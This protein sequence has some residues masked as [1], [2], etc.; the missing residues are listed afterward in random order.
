MTKN[1]SRSGLDDVSGSGS[2]SSSDSA[3]AGRLELA[4]SS[5]GKYSSAVF[6]LPSK[7]LFLLSS[8]NDNDTD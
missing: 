4:P 1:G 2:L 7:L 3:F 6:R 5:A 8:Y